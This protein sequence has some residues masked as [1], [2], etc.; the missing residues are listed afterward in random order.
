LDG[1][2]V[3]TE[4]KGA[5]EPHSEAVIKLRV[6]GTEEHTAAEGSRP[7]ERPRQGACRKSL[8]TFLPVHRGHPPDRLQSPRAGRQR[9]PRTPR[10]GC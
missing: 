8:A 1:F 7:G 3:I 2:R 6:D 9:L 5:N 10:F 4:K